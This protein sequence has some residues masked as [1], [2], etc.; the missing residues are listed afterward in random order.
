CTFL[1]GVL[2]HSPGMFVAAL[3]GIGCGAGF[4][5][6]PLYTLLQ[7]RAPKESKGNVVSASNFLNVV[8][9]I[10]AVLVF[11]AMT[12]AFEGLLGPSVTKQEVSADPSLIVLYIDELRKQRQIPALL[13]M[14]TSV[15][16][17]GALMVLTRRLPD[18]YLR[19]AIWIRACG[20]NTLRTIGIEHMPTD[21]PVLLLTNCSIFHAVL[22]LIAGVDRSPRVVLVEQSPPERSWLRRLARHSRLI[23]VPAVPGAAE[24][25]GALQSGIRTLQKG[26]MV[27]L[28][29][30]QA[31]CAA[32]ISRLIDAWRAAA[33]GAVVLPVCCTAAMPSPAESPGSALRYPR[34]IFGQPLPP[35]DP[36]VSIVTAIERLATAADDQ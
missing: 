29:V 3:F 18:F 1:P 11:Y 20:H 30:N 35:Q 2:R 22:D 12:F 10:F 13:F 27:A 34:V 17:F 21:G 23:S 5:L 31:D 6:V 19:T 15:M 4:Y 16:T 25:N 9:G 8:G 36:L 14:S 32:D 24:W 7:H 33:P 26:E 28:T